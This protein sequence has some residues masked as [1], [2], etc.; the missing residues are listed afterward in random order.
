MKKLMIAAAVVAVGMGAFA[1]DACSPV[2]KTSAWVYQWKFSGKTTWGNKDVGTIG[3]LNC[4][5]VTGQCTYRV[6]TSLKI[7]GYT[8]ACD[9]ASC[10]DDELGLGGVNFPEVN[11]ARAWSC[12]DLLASEAPDWSSRRCGPVR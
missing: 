10:S 9:V 3:T 12:R 6:K 5:P 7:Q 4:V 1:A 2:V 11:E 8:F